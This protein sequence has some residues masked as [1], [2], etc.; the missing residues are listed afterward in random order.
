MKDTLCSTI[1]DWF[2]NKTVH[3]SKYPVKYN[4]AIKNQN[5]IGWQHLFMGHFPT[6]WATKHGPFVTPLGTTARH[7]CGKPL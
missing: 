6:A 4:P 5:A 2:D 3:P 7:T 1:A